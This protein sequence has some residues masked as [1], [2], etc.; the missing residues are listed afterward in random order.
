ME[1][2]FLSLRWLLLF[3]S[4]YIGSGEWRC[5]CERPD[6]A[7]DNTVGECVCVRLPTHM[8]IQC[9]IDW[10]FVAIP[11]LSFCGV[12]RFL[13]ASVST[14]QCI[15]ARDT[16]S[17]APRLSTYVYVQR[18]FSQHFHRAAKNIKLFGVLCCCN[19]DRLLYVAVGAPFGHGW[20]EHHPFCV[21]WLVDGPKSAS[22]CIITSKSK[23]CQWNFRLYSAWG[24]ACR[25][26]THIICMRWM[27]TFP[28]FRVWICFSM[29]VCVW[30][31]FFLFTHYYKYIQFR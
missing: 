2:G 1:N 12:V 14:A 29:C 23:Y 6:A 8:H 27:I 10:S 4:F 19:S 20:D 13:L 15:Y 25:S 11:L 24:T 31:V 22:K 30:M 5:G 26:T 28:V 3:L 7:P 16:P 21:C 9:C 18:K 17:L